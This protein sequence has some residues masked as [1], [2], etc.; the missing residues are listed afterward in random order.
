M[1]RLLECALA[2]LSSSPAEI[3]ACLR[4]CPGV[5]ERRARLSGRAPYPARAGT[6]PSSVARS[7][8][9]PGPRTSSGGRARPGVQASSR[10]RRFRGIRAP[11]FEGVWPFSVYI[12]GETWPQPRLKVWNRVSVGAAPGS[13]GGRRTRPAQQAPAAHARIRTPREEETTGRLAPAAGV[14]AREY[15]S[16]APGSRGGRRIPPGRGQAPRV[17]HA[18]TIPPVHGQAPAAELDQACK[19]ARERGVG[20]P[21]KEGFPAKVSSLFFAEFF[22]CSSFCRRSRNKTP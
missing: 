4:L 2:M 11:H 5:R 6:G 10:T 17:W 15:V 7:Y 18:L 3:P 1:K 8:H 13:L 16:A 9:T 21:T 19:R 14:C 20:A 12:V 22:C